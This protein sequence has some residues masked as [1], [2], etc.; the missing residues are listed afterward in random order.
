MSIENFTVNQIN[1][2]VFIC[3]LVTRCDN[4]LW[5]KHLMLD[6]A[7]DSN[8]FLLLSSYALVAVFIGYHE[9]FT[10]HLL[11]KVSSQSNKQVGFYV[12]ISNVIIFYCVMSLFILYRM[13][14]C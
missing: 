9:N 11:V 2:L 13:P 1:G 6:Y 8:F 5:P 7:K 12:Q 14:Q 10:V 3:K 4:N